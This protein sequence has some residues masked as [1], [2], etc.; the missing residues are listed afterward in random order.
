MG[1]DEKETIELNG[2]IKVG[3][4]ILGIQGFAKEISTF[5]NLKAPPTRTPVMRTFVVNPEYQFLIAS[6]NSSIIKR[7]QSAVQAPTFPLYLGN[8]ECLASVRKVSDIADVK[9][10]RDNAKL[11]SCV[12]PFPRGGEAVARTELR[13]EGG[14]FYPPHVY[15]TVHSFKWT[16]K[17]RDIESFIR[18]M[19]FTGCQVEMK[20]GR[21][22][23]YDW[24][25][26]RVCLF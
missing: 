22:D 19:M 4:K 18:L 9:P 14:V 17:G 1:L 20:K 8:T 12:I 7:L 26:E 13:H 21:V 25:G 23:T 24:L 6:D 16:E 3:V 11:Y 10:L 15:R 2:Q 5:K